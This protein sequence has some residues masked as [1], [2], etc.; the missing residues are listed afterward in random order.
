MFQEDNVESS[1]DEDVD[2]EMEAVNDGDSGDDMK[3]ESDDDE[4][5]ENVGIWAW[6]LKT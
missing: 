1:D 2:A 3:E 4:D 6:D 5:Y